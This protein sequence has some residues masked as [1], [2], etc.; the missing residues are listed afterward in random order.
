[1]RRHVFAEVDKTNVYT[2]FELGTNSGDH[3]YVAASPK[4]FAVA[5]R[6]G[7]GKTAVIP[8]SQTG[9]LPFDQPCLQGHAG[10]VTDIQFNPFN[11]NTLATASTDA[12]IKLWS[13]PEAGLTEKMT[14]SFA[15]LNGHMK[16]TTLIQWHPTAS[17]VLASA[18]RDQ[19]VKI[20]D[21]EN[22]AD[23]LTI[24][25]PIPSL[26]SDVR[27]SYKGDMLAAACKD[28]MV[29]V[30][31][32]RTSCAA[33]AAEVQA[34]D[35]AKVVNLAFL[36]RRELLLS[37]GFTR[38]SRRELKIWDPRKFDTPVGAH[39]LDQSAG[40]LMPF[41][42]DDSSVL[43]VGGKGD[44]NM[45]HFEL[46]DEATGPTL[47]P[48]EE[49]R[50]SESIKGLAMLPKRAVDVGRCE[51]ARFVKL[52]R[53]GVKIVSFLV[54]RKSDRFQDDLFPDTVAPNPATS[55]EEWFKGATPEPKRMSM[56][57]EKNGGATTASAVT[58][59]KSTGKPTVSKDS[60]AASASASASA[61]ASTA[62]DGGA[63][64]EVATLKREVAKLKDR[65][66]SLETDLDTATNERDEAL[67]KA[68]EAASGDG[69][70]GE[71]TLAALKEENEQLKASV[72]KL[73]ATVM[74]LMNNA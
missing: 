57:P 24:S 68:E 4:F 46:S 53:D 56:D 15:T 1:M 55:A 51:T 63:S 28:K 62:S 69:S 73:K 9:K 10:D 72:E 49:V 7:A 25:D 6:G 30:F 65:I 36:G 22:C 26:V 39:D 43:Y 27:W 12:T 67:K 17:N 8:F 14:E 54:P 41:W 42:D 35:G 29:R 44:G 2:G 34:H 61:A 32:P 66:S 40:V 18:S 16:D 37:A 58:T 47:Y 71:E 70:G 23:V 64:A 19:S 45:R 21:V 38:S 5:L 20:W 11:D 74:T 13:I 52:L 3:F 31:D 60:A 33:P 50:G 48:L 59:I